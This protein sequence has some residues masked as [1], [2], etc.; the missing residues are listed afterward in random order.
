[1][2]IY[3]H[4]YIHVSFFV[5]FI[6]PTPTIPIAN[7][8]QHSIHPD[9]SNDPDA[10]NRHGSPTSPRS[11]G[12][13]PLK[14][15]VKTLE[16]PLAGPCHGPSHGPSPCPCHGPSP[17]PCPCPG[18]PQAGPGPPLAGP[19]LCA[20]VG[21]VNRCGWR[22]HLRASLPIPTSSHICPRHEEDLHPDRRDSYWENAC[23]WICA[24]PAG[25]CVAKAGRDGQPRHPVSC[26]VCVF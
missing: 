25:P 24:G 5:L 7:H 13:D 2:S 4:I 16:S 6:A 10:S 8:C 18:P 17:C 15:H 19:T 26:K 23:P 11:V 1:M 20:T 12:G 9:A 14:M 22:N 21:F 3:V